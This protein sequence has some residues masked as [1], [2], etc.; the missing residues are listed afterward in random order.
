MHTI[1]GMCAMSNGVP[2]I[3]PI[4]GASGNPGTDSNIH[5]DAGQK[6]AINDFLTGVLQDPPPV[7]AQARNEEQL[8]ENI[9]LMEH[10][11]L[12]PQP[13]ILE[14]LVLST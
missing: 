6:N 3:C 13:I 12:T 1:I 8:P 4:S 9:R 5:A 14:E 11:F 7:V 2:A 10:D